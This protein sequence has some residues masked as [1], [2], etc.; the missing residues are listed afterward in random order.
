MQGRRSAYHRSTGTAINVKM[1]SRSTGK[2]KPF[3]RR[4]CFCY[5]KDR[6]GRP[7]GRT[8]PVGNG[9]K[10]FFRQPFGSTVALSSPGGCVHEICGTYRRRRDGFA[11]GLADWLGTDAAAGHHVPVGRNS[12][13]RSGRWRQLNCRNACGRKPMRQVH[14]TV[15]AAR[16]GMSCAVRAHRG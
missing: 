12:G 9:G 16:R 15:A 6:N 4:S 14:R 8:Y 10:F 7:C 5:A 13:T 3:C 1:T 11:A 2:G